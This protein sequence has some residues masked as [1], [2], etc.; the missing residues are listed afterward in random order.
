V[1]AVWF[2][3]A[4]DIPSQHGEAVANFLI[5]NGAPG[6]RSED[7]GGHT[8]LVAHFAS[9]PPLDSLRRL[10]VDLGG[11]SWAADSMKVC[12]R[13]IAEEDWAENWKLHFQPQLVGE[14]LC[15]CPSWAST[16]PPGR[17]AVV[18]DPGMAFGTGHHASTRGCL[19]LL[20]SAVRRARITRGLDVGTGSGVLAIAMAKLGV[21]DVSAVDNDPTA[22]A[23]AAANATANEVAPNICIAPTL[24]AVDGTFD[25]VAANLFA[26][27]LHEL[28]PRLARALRA[29]GLLICSGLLT[30]DECAL[31]SRYEAL[32]LQVAERYQDQAWVTLG[33]RRKVST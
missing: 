1:P 10:C 24:D 15:I 28:A 31:R 23:I 18:I 14:R 5:E 33:L 3:I 9:A 29:S 30:A 2:E 13:R 22:R 17:I 21:M 20:D 27:L 19:L 8:L 16:P 7:R 11:D 25:L 4:V 12:V 6:I 32:G 26:N